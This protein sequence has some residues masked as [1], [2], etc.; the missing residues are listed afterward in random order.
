MG[1]KE[2]IW[3][4]AVTDILGEERKGRVVASRRW[5]D[6]LGRLE[7]GE[8]FRIIVLE[9]P[10]V[11]E[12][13]LSGPV[14]V[15]APVSLAGTSLSEPGSLWAA[16]AS[17]YIQGRM[18]IFAPYPLP[19]GRRHT[20]S[21]RGLQ[22]E[23]VAK[24]L[25]LA[26]DHGRWWQAAAQALY[27]P[28]PA[29]SVEP[30]EVH[31][32]LQALVEKAQASLPPQGPEELAAALARLRSWL[33]CQGEEE[34][35]KEAA[36]TFGTATALAAD[37]YAARALAQSPEEA[38]AVAEARRFLAEAAAPQHELELDRTLAREQMSYVVVAVEPHRLPVG[39]AALEHFQAR[40][41]P[42]YE[43]H[44]RQ[45]WA[46]VGQ[47]RDR[48]LKAGA[49]AQALRRLDA[50]RELG[51]PVG[52]AAL[53]RYH[54]LLR[55]LDPCTEEGPVLPGPMSAR[56]PQCHLELGALPPVQEV[57]ETLA[58]LDQALGEQMARL[59]KA[60]ASVAISQAYDPT[61]ERLLKV[62]QASQLTTLAQLLD[63][64]LTAFL[65]CFLVE[66]R[67]KEA[68]APLLERLQAG[69]T[70]SRQEVERAGEEVLRILRSLAEGG[71]HS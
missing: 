10:L 32:Q 1:A 56:C 26:W 44:H 37:I 60:L 71:H 28:H 65:R 63:D 67:I 55:Y 40:Y 69:E 6:E 66:T 43:A 18:R 19:V 34:V 2:R 23:A 57:E 61:L 27:A 64:R 7:E 46:A 68:I 30:M 31:R 11:E 20:L 8:E 58:A 25:V 38:L 13:Q 39:K 35:V 50:L 5:R 42:A 70:P 17:P 47:L 9:E 54:A 24:A 36:K 33:K 3:T 53:A 51:P 12:P 16:G 59:A 41:R 62:V 21:E 22:L 15:C 52:T 14:V 48:L 4:L 49:K 29:P 45:Y